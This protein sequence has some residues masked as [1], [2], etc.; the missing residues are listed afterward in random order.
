[1][2]A[3]MESVNERTHNVPLGSVASSSSVTREMTKLCEY[4]AAPDS[5]RAIASMKLVVWGKKRRGRGG[6][7]WAGMY[8]VRG[9]CLRCVDVVCVRACVHG[10]VRVCVVMCVEDVRVRGRA[11]LGASDR[12]HE[13]GVRGRVRMCVC[14]CV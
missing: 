13:A 9:T 2:C 1:M 12:L 8:V 5:V 3:A 14:V 11:R 10:V 4:G 6:G 7:E